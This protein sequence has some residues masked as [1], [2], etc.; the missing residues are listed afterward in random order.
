M[1]DKRKY[2]NEYLTKY[3]Y[4][5]HN[6]NISNTTL[7]E[8]YNL[9]KY[10]KIANPMNKDLYGFYAIYFVV[11]GHIDEGIKFN[12]YALKHNSLDTGAFYN[13]V[14]IYIDKKDNDNLIKMYNQS[15]KNGHATYVNYLINLYKSNNDMDKVN[16]I[17]NMLINDKQRNTYL[18][19]VCQ[20]TDFKFTKS[21]LDTVFTIQLPTDAPLSLKL[22]KSVFNTQK[23]DL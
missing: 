1:A 3:N 9:Y 14:N 15:I 6:D 5:F 22:M 18:S 4:T 17:F 11:N 16:E 7:D 20:I 13:L 12:E 10:G 19:T 2:I 23:I 8:I 21:M